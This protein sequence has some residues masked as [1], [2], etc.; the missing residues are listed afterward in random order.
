[1]YL[2]N[3]FR[4]WFDKIHAEQNFETALILRNKTTDCFLENLPNLMSHPQMHLRGNDS[5][6]W[7][8]KFNMEI[9]TLVC[10]QKYLDVDILTTL[11]KI[12]NQIRHTRV[13]FLLKDFVQIQ[14][15]HDQLMKF[16][17]QYE[18]TNV[19]I[20]FDE[21]MK[22]E[23]FYRYLP[24]PTYQVVRS[25]FRN[26]TTIYPKQWLN[27]K[28]KVFLTLP[29]QIEP[30]SVMYVDR[31]GE[32]KLSGFV[33]KL[34]QTYAE[35]YNAT[36]QFLYPVDVGEII[37][38]NILEK[39]VENRSLDIPISLAGVQ[40]FNA[41]HNGSYPIELSE[42]DYH[43][44]SKGSRIKIN[45]LN[46]FLNDKV[47]PGILGQSYIL[48]TTP[49]LAYKFLYMSIFMLGLMMNTLFA[50][51][52]KTLITT[53]PNLPEVT[54]FEE[55]RKMRMRMLFDEIEVDTIDR[56][57]G[58]NLLEPIRDL[59]DTADTLTFQ[60]QRKSLNTSHTYTVTTSLW[61]VFE[62]LQRFFSRKLF[63]VPNA[64]V[65]IKFSL[66]KVPL[67]ENSVLKESFDH[68]SGY[69]KAA[70]LFQHWY[71]STFQDMLSAKKISIK[72]KTKRNH[73]SI[74][75][76]KD[77]KWIWLLLGCGLIAGTIAFQ[78]ELLYYFFKNNFKQQRIRTFK[79]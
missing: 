17:A 53:H 25:S 2:G 11:A 62:E 38:L 65:L 21:L 61:R 50:A 33:A 64:M 75:T 63:Q 18:L 46:I 44:N 66:M 55:L 49:K 45:Y 23:L 28:G 42:C 40:N 10:L 73:Y 70:G 74:L 6:M 72:D 59:I 58:T 48:H 34:I 14:D 35:I 39:F 37:H 15:L 56:I 29:D 7:K 5:F 3:W 57:L 68:Y 9:L 51:H 43:T 13:I 19:I 30:R 22:D 8:N 76:V 69:A 31:Y 71:S 32:K 16:C 41:F 77:F 26:L 1:M 47:V 79:E 52:L 27:F 12:L 24:Y 36:L 20:L 78:I 4:K 60:N 67:Q 54:N